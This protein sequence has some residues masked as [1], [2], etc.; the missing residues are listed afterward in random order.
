MRDLRG[1]VAA[2]G[3]AI[4]I[5][6]TAQAQA[7]DDVCFGGSKYSLDQVI[8]A[9]TEVINFESELSTGDAHIDRGSA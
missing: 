9:C 3:L 1:R 6:G 8:R 5:G 2:S 4:A 7:R